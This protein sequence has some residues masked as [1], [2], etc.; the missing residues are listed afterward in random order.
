MLG[1][2]RVAVHY[3]SADG[4]HR[5]SNAYKHCRPQQV[6][7]GGHTALHPLCR[8]ERFVYVDEDY[9]EYRHEKHH[10]YEVAFFEQ[11]AWN[12]LEQY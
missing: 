1:A 7:A 5:H 9:S 6:L 4:Y 3:Y 10:D 8:T 11:V 12:L 2:A